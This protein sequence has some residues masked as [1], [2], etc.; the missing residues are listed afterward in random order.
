[1]LKESLEQKIHFF[2]HFFSENFNIYFQIVES[3]KLK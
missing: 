3:R 2:F 1:M